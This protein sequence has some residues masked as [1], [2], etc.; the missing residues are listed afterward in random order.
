VGDFRRRVGAPTTIALTATATPQVRADIRRTLARDARQMPLFAAGI[1]RP[2]LELEVRECWDDD[3]K[4]AEIQDVADR[5]HGTGIVYFAL[6]KHLELYASRL[7]ELDGGLALEIY[8]GQLPPARKRRVYDRFIR[9]EPDERLLLLATNAFGMG[10]DKPDIRSIVHAQVPGSV[11]AYYQEVGRAGRDAQP[12]TCALLYSEDDLAIQQQFVEWINPSPDLLRRA[13]H[14]LEDWPHGD[15]T[16][17]DVRPLIVARD[18]GDRRVESC[19]TALAKMGVVEESPMRDHYRFVRSLRDDEVERDALEEKRRRDL[20][21]LL[22]MVTLAR[23]GDMR[24]FIRDYFALE[25]EG[26][27]DGHG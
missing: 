16:V 25:D 19:L 15:F 1:D 22:D 13:G 12:S 26:T 3:A 21:R 6:I 23:S 17:D 9:A 7:R 14:V 10:V 4:L 11:E 8:H 5:R 18:R 24:G 2:N 27:V 20:R